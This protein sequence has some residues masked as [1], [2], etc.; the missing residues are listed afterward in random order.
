MCFSN[1]SK[2][3]NVGVENFGILLEFFHN[4]NFV[5]GRKNQPFWSEENLG[6]GGVIPIPYGTFLEISSFTVPLFHSIFS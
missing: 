1:I 3:E 4:P 2:F 6:V 5:Y